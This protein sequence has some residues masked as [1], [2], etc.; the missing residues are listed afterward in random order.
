M[1]SQIVPSNIDGTFPVA[2]QDNSSQGFRDNFTNTKN[3]FQYAYNEITD[4]QSKVIVKSALS[5]T[6]LNNDMAGALIGNVLTQGYREKV[7]DFGTTSGA[8]S[9]DLSLASYFTITLASS[10]TFTFANVPTLG[11]NAA[12]YTF[13]IE[14]VV[15]NM[16]YTI[17][18]PMSVSKNAATI[19]GL[20]TGTNTITF[21]ETGTFTFEF[22]TVDSGTTYSILDRSRA[23]DT[24]QG[25]SLTVTNVVANATVAGITLS[26]DTNG[27]GNVTA[28]NFIGNIIST[29]SNSAIF[30]GNVTAGNI[31]TSGAS[32]FI[33]GNI[34]TASQTAI[35]QV[36]TLTT[37][38]VSGN[39]TAGNIVVS[40]LFDMCGAVQ[41]T[42]IQY[43]TAANAGSTN[44][45]S[46]VSLAIV[47]PAG[48]IA[49]YTLIMPATPVNGQVIRLV[50]G[51]TITSLT[52]TA[53]S[54]TIK[55]ALTTA[56]NTAG[57]TWYYYTAATTWFRV[58]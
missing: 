39:L 53:G 26:V 2:G 4:L 24:V 18:L 10:V 46:N 1:T 40:G 17:T 45:Y 29:G 42:G 55:G 51:N 41:E 19:A 12:N 11:T 49:S 43:I 47:N 20:N 30:S 22:T 38:N 33:Y 13:R 56:A 34:A 8:K 15:P 21:T 14:V 6:T 36:G 35:T 31:I 48:T 50:F 16:G 9:V 32:S 52:H 27:V 54:N 58:N 57:G 25:G 44:L 28:T 5:G 3:N 7:Y 37:A 23:R